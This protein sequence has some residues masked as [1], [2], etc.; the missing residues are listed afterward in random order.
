MLFMLITGLFLINLFRIMYLIYLLGYYNNDK[1]KLRNTKYKLAIAV[2]IHLLF[3]YIT[4][5]GIV[6]VINKILNQYN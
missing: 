5:N 2:V 4:V 1:D 3:I 6:E